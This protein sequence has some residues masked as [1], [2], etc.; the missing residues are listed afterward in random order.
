[1]ILGQKNSHGIAD[2]GETTA[3]F[4][5]YFLRATGIYPQAYK[6]AISTP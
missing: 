3:N 6:D 5:R 1:M 4:C 2:M